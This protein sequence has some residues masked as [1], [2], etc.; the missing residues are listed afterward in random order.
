MDY[1]IKDIIGSET[2]IACVQSGQKAI[3]FSL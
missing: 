3:S 2:E 1:V